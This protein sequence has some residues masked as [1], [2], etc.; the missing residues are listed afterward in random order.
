MTVKIEVIAAPG[1]RKCAG[2]QGELRA[3]AASV[4]GED[5]LIWREISVLEELDYAV[6]LGVLTTPAIAVNG[7]LKFSSLPTPDQFRAL[8]TRLEPR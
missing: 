1:C 2:A 6:S 5:G 4:L 8:L 7:E 3:V